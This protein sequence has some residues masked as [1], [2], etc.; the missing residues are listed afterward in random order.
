MFEYYRQLVPGGL[1]LLQGDALGDDPY[2][3]FRELCDPHLVVRAALKL[4]EMF[5]VHTS[6]DPHI[7]PGVVLMQRDDS[8]DRHPLAYTLIGR[9]YKG[10]LL[11]QLDGSGF[12]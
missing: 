11:T 5:Q 9:K 6:A 2:S 3:S 12:M 4:H 8:P 1:V 10:R 7:V